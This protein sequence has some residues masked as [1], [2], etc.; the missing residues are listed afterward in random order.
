[1]HLFA[2]ESV[3]MASMDRSIGVLD[4]NAVDGQV[5]IDC[6]SDVKVAAEGGVGDFLDLGKRIAIR[7]ALCIPMG[8]CHKALTDL[9]G[10]GALEQGFLKMKAVA[11]A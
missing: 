9:S 6:F 1:M 3:P 2:V 8:L 11:V 10:G 4:D 5:Q 7:D